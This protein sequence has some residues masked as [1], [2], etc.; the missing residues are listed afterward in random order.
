MTTASD[1]ARSKEMLLAV[2]DTHIEGRSRDTSVSERNFVTALIMN[3][4]RVAKFLGLPTRK[5]NRETTKEKKHGK[6]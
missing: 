2:V 3:R 5:F 4:N 6:E 1:N